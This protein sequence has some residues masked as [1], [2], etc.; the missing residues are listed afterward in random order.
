MTLRAPYSLARRLCLLSALLLAA[1][2]CEEKSAEPPPQEK[3][4]VY[5]GRSE[6]LLKPVFER[7]ERETGV[8]VDVAYGQSTPAMANQ[9]ALELRSGGATP[10]DLFLAQDCGH[11]GALAKEEI[12]AP[13]PAEVLART[14]ERFRDPGGRWIGTSGR[15]RVLV[16]DPQRTPREKLPKSLAELP[17]SGLKI[18]WAP[19]NGSFRAHVS[20]MLVHWGEDKTRAWLEAVKATSPLRFTKNSPQVTAVAE[21]QI[22]VGWV[23]HYYLHKLRKQNPKLA[24][25]NASFESAGEVDN[26]LMLAGLGITAPEGPR[27]E[28]AER[29]A[30]FLLSEAAQNHFA[31]EIGEYPTVAGVSTEEEVTPL[32]EIPLAPVGAEDLGHVGRVA[33]LLDELDL[34]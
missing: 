19:G 16:Y 11:L 13:L 14:D 3:L 34:R 1:L 31:Q 4:I 7:F 33:A 24:A 8:K 21:G 28:L 5:C 15:L 27:R 2:G 22:D 26:L 12:L 25:E 10:C 20:A 17:T 32:A 23:N 6:G 18:G 29:L 9:I 30:A